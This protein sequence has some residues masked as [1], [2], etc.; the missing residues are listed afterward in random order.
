MSI[1]CNREAIEENLKMLWEAEAKRG[2]QPV[3]KPAVMNLI[4]AAADRA[5]A[6]LLAERLGE[7]SRQHPG[8]MLILMPPAEQDAAQCDIVMDVRQQLCC[9]RIELP[10]LPDEGNTGLIESLLIPG[11]PLVLWWRHRFAPGH[12]VFDRLV[13]QA[14]RLLVDSAEYPSMHRWMDTVGQLIAEPTLPAIITD[15]NWCRLYPWRSALAELFDLPEYRNLLQRVDAVELVYAAPAADTLPPTSVLLVFG[16]LAS[17]LGWQPQSRL[18]K[19][20]EPAQEWLLS[21]GGQAV[22][23]YFLYSPQLPQESGGLQQITLSAGEL[24]FTV[25]LYGDTCHMRIQVECAEQCSREKVVLLEGCHD[26]QMLCQ[27]LTLA[28]RD[29]I[30][31]ETLAF[32][33]REAVFWR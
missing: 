12:P 4:T 29:I 2:E 22:T 27:E 23:A 21:H 24:R 5:D 8:R 15:M 13:R 30:Y 9:E 16:W 26:A 19:K 1:A 31:A 28:R 17:R 20:G 3:W 10:A 18:L 33:R 25:A 11:L 32:F 6:A 14:A 7:V